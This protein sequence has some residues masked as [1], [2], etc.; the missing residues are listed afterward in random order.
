[1][2][3]SITCPHRGH[4]ETIELTLDPESG[5]IVEIQRCTASDPADCDRLC[6]RLLNQKLEIKGA[7]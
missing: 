7:I 2:A 5:R 1:M 4:L 3:K 6:M